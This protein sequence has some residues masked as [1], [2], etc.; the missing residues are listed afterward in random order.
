MCMPALT[1]ADTTLDIRLLRS[2]RHDG[3]AGSTLVRLI[4]AADSAVI[5]ADT[6]AGAWHLL[7]HDSLGRRYLLGGAFQMGAWLPLRALAF[8]NA[9]TGAITRSTALAGR[10]ALAAVSRCDGRYVALVGAEDGLSAM[11]VLA[12]DTQRDTIAV[13]QARVPGPPPLR[14][15]AEVDMFRSNG[16]PYAWGSPPWDGFTPMDGALRF[17]ADGR[18]VVTGGGDTPYRRARGARAR[19]LDLS[20]IFHQTARA[21]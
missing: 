1:F 11:H 2:P 9:A 18:L 20:R 12:W 4:R 19:L 14:D 16:L 6:L 21:R 7:G 8:V 10:Y 17:R 15:A 3:D 5:S 13:L